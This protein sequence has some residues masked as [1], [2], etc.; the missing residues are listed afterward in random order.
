MKLWNK[1][2]SFTM[3]HNQPELRK[4]RKNKERKIQITSAC[5]HYIHHF[6]H[7]RLHHWMIDSLIQND[8]EI[9][10]DHRNRNSL[11]AID[12]RCEFIVSDY[13]Q[14]AW[15]ESNQ[16]ICRHFIR[17]I[18]ENTTFIQVFMI[19][20]SIHGC[21]VFRLEKLSSR[22]LLHIAT[23]IQIWI[24]QSIIKNGVN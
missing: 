22:N 4:D 24:T 16:S 18:R 14:T 9:Y 10:I 3:R 1:S 20:T 13:E 11:P 5:M 19:R 2:C 6:S 21:F 8:H 15:A 17:K 23:V 7:H 12:L